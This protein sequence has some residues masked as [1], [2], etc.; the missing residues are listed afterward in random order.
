M[1]CE[2]E[3]DALVAVFGS[4]VG[5]ALKLKPPVTDDHKV[6]RPY[7]SSLDAESHRS[8]NLVLFFHSD[9]LKPN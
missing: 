8:V 1:E 7:A 2:R 9:F 4:H 5:L 6:S 3:I